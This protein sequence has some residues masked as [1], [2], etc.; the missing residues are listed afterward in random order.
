VNS[1]IQIRDLQVHKGGRRVCS[2]S[3]L[4]IRAGE[5]L[6]VT[7]ANGA[8]KTTLLRVIAGLEPFNAGECRISIPAKDRVYVH[9]RPCLFRGSVL[10]NV[11]YGLKARQRPRDQRIRL[12]DHWMDLLGVSHLSNRPS[13]ALSGGECRRVA[14]ARALVLQPP[15]LLLD[16]PF[17]E[18]D[19]EGIQCVLR[20]LAASPATIV[21]ASPLS[22]P[23]NPF[24]RSYP[25][26]PPR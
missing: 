1:L 25:L 16:E 19:E 24:G 4:E 8:G 22:L 9:Q 12:A 14:L 2:V 11:S 6:A 3:E 21:I 18:L 23:G 20:G 5:R 13:T 10:F 15:L 7:G 17:A 26:D